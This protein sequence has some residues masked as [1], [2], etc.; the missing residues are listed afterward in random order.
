MPHLEETTE[1]GPGDEGQAPHLICISS[2][3]S[4][5]PVSIADVETPPVPPAKSDPTPK[6][7][8]GK[9]HFF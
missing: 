9:A 1:R 4:P 6:P 5:F 2:A 3:P 7:L 8:L